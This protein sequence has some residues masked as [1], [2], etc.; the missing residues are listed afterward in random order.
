MEVKPNILVV[1]SINMDLVLRSSK[2]P[3]AGE[4]FIGKDYCYIPGGKGANQA[5]AAALLGA[6]VSFAG[7]AGSDSN[8]MRLKKLL[9]ERGIS[10]EFLMVDQNSQTGLA[11]VMLED[12]GQNR[13]VVFPGANMEI[14]K[15]DIQKAFEKS[16]DAVLVQLEVPT[17]IVIETCRLA[18]EKNIPVFVDAGPAQSFPLENIKGIELL[19]PNES[20]TYAMCGINVDT[21]ERAEEAAKILMQRSDARFVVI[22]MGKD[23]AM[24]Y[25]KDKMQFY[26]AIKVEVIDTTAAGDAFTAALTFEYIK[27]GDIERAI[28]FAIIVGAITVTRLGA[29]PSL[30]NIEEIAEF[31]K[32][33]GL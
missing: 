21:K 29:Q 8:G 19:S 22:K 9:E 27:H 33:K 6:S 13:I 3:V 23:G 14:Q 25:S 17:E 7:K 30:P 32:I 10:T 15:E 16:Y 18:K 1:G 11:V 4:S 28:K 20:E 2:I 26:P 5:V 12:N 31:I 24:L